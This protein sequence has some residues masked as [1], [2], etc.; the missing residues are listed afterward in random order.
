MYT[1]CSHAVNFHSQGRVILTVIFTSVRILACRRLDFVLHFDLLSG[2][3]PGEPCSCRRSCWLLWQRETP[4]HRAQGRVSIQMS[5][6]TARTGSI[7][8]RHF[9]LPPH[10]T[11]VFRTDS[12]LFNSL[13]FFLNSRQ[14]TWL[15]FFYLCWK[16]LEKILYL[17]SQWKA[18]PWHP[19]P[20]FHK[21]FFILLFL[22]SI[23]HN[24]EQE[25]WRCSSKQA[26]SLHT[27]EKH[28]CCLYN[29][30]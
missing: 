18:F 22:V 10:R 9:F 24:K 8:S 29:C 20:A 4:Q 19:M 17:Y 15:G 12:L 7:P 1:H 30:M 3:C 21:H 13:L 25:V 2:L 26:P 27:A 5:F 28:N 16:I 11:L 14:I 6:L 23:V